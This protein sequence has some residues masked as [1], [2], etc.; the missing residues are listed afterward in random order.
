MERIEVT[1]RKLVDEEVRECE[2]WGVGTP[3]STEYRVWSRSKR[4]YINCC[5]G[6]ERGVLDNVQYNCLWGSINQSRV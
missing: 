2:A 4:Y 1:W 5:K 6:W 3:L